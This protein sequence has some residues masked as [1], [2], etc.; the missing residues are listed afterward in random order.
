MFK[1]MASTS[2]VFVRQD[3]PIGTPQSPYEESYNVLSRGEK[4][5]KIK[6]RGRTTRIAI[7]RLKPAYSRG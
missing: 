1:D 2:K 3:V 6:I 5:Y 4:W 7:D